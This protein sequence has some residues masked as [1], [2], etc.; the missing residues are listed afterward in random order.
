[1]RQRLQSPYQNGCPSG[2]SIN[3]GSFAEKHPPKRQNDA[4]AQAEFA[5]HFE[6]DDVRST[7]EDD[8]AKLIDRD[9]RE[10]PAIEVAASLLSLQSDVSL[11]HYLLCDRQPKYDPTRT[12]QC[13]PYVAERLTYYPAGV[14]MEWCC[15]QKDEFSNGTVAHQ[16]WFPASKS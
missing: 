8:P 16:L 3:Y 14:D 2:S 9:S 7:T 13:L 15:G 4:A 11:E 12:F 10:A 6:S 5:R 1:M